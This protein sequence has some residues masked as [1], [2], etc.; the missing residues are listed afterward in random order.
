MHLILS[1]AALH[2]NALRGNRDEN[3]ESIIYH[4][5]AVKS[6]NRRLANPMVEHS[7]G[8]LGA[9]LGVRLQEPEF[10]NDVADQV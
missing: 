8:I 4:L 3:R 2:L 1:N 5:S 7:D 6:V 10:L 9:I